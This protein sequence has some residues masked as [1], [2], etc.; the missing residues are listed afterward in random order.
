VHGSGT[1]HPQARLRFRICA[2]RRRACPPNRIQPLFRTPECD[3]SRLAARLNRAA[4]N[5]FQHRQGRNGAAALEP[6][7]R[8]DGPSAP[9]SFLQ[10]AEIASSMHKLRG[11]VTPGHIA[12]AGETVRATLTSFERKAQGSFAGCRRRVAHLSVVRLFRALGVP[13][14]EASSRGRLIDSVVV[15]R[16]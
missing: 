12:A 1:G 9:P 4:A 3:S 8:P 7:N 6:G 14:S 13:R 15:V 5:R 2:V 10:R 16:L 11:S